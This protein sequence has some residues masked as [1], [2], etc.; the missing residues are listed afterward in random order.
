MVLIS[1]G[2]I[3]RA[4]NDSERYFFKDQAQFGDIGKM[5]EFNVRLSLGSREDLFGEGFQSRTRF[6]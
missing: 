4:L 1:D 5:K 3:F 2:C 6:E